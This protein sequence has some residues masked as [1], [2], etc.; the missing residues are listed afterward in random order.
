MTYLRPLLP[1][2]ACIALLLA[3]AP[4]ASIAAANV[5]AQ[6]L[7]F[8]PVVLIPA[9]R[10]GRMS[11]VDI[12][13]PL[14]LAVIGA[15][16]L[17]MGAGHPVRVFAIGLVYLA[18]GLRMGL[19]AVRLWR[20]GHLD[21]ELPRYAYQQIRWERRGIEN[22][23]LIMQ[24]EALSQGTANMSFL[25]LP[26]F[27]IAANEAPSVHPLEILGLLI[28]I[29]AFA[30]ES[31][32]DSQKLAFLREMREQGR[33]S[34]VCDVGLWRYSR[35]PNYFAE[36]MVWNGLIVAAL[37]SWIA[38]G[39]RVPVAIWLVLGACT[40]FI[41]RIMYTVLVQYTGAKPAEFYSVQKR[42]EYRAY[43]AR[44]NMFFPGPAKSGD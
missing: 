2:L 10:T 35:H 19:A 26:A 15:L 39:E 23:P 17:A 37:P 16:T 34:V 21:E 20:K 9:W 29:G 30:M 43:Q 44:T 8:V 14:G 13:W 41:C 42:P 33:R 38:F 22:V 27:L 36:W 3:T 28:W 5:A 12:G 11:Y 32:A 6:L 18:I 7:L 31:V 40:L 1:S 4:L 24:S 25:A